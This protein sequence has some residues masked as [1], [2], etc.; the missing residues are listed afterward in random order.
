MTAKDKTL[1]L[2]IDSFARVAGIQNRSV[3]KAGRKY[4]GLIVR[5]MVG[6]YKGYTAVLDGII[7]DREH[8]ALF[9]C[10]VL[11]KRTG[12]ILNSDIHTRSYHPV[13]SFEILETDNG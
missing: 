3:L 8:G 11:N 4:L 5:M 10:Y 6:K 13:S 9:C 1:N 12:E 2:E 7:L